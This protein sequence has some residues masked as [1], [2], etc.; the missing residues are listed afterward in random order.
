MHE[1]RLFLVV[2]GVKTRSNG[3]KLES[4]KFH[5]NMWEK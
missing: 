5:T 4:K 2:Y 3:P 1:A